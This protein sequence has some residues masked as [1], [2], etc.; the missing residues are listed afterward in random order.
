MLIIKYSSQ[1]V[2]HYITWHPNKSLAHSPSTHSACRTQNLFLHS[3]QTAP[4]QG[5]LLWGLL[6]LE[7]ATS[8]CVGNT[9]CFM[10]YALWPNNPTVIWA[11]WEQI[12]KDITTTTDLMKKTVM[13]LCWPHRLVNLEC[14]A[15]F[16]C[17]VSLTNMTG[18]SF[19]HDWPTSL[20]SA[21]IKKVMWLDILI[22]CHLNMRHE[23]P[24]CYPL[25]PKS[26]TISN[27]CSCGHVIICNSK[28]IFS[29]WGKTL[30]LFE[31]YCSVFTGFWRQTKWTLGE[32]KLYFLQRGSPICIQP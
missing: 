21:V 14:E 30:A 16:K 8:Y 31:N 20:D 9:P 15:S 5:H 3:T 22:F 32:L 23:L 28:N 19:Q 29:L 12:E 1:L 10:I 17:I 2:R 27:L 6:P 7:Q 13:F 11:F 4:G 24:L 25:S 26:L 18:L